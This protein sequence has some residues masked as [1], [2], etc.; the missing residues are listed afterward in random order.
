MP[1]ML[2]ELKAVILMGE[3]NDRLFTKENADYLYPAEIAEEN[4]LRDS[5]AKLL[6]DR[7]TRQ[8]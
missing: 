4:M 1:T 8:K 7:L 5:K 6:Y 3:V 2:A